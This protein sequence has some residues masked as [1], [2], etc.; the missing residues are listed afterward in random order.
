MGTDTGR[1]SVFDKDLLTCL[2]FFIK[3]G[4]TNYSIYTPQGEYYGSASDPKGCTDM[5]KER[6][7]RLENDKKRE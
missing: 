3:V 6:Q 2:G 4:M 1:V 7:E 5:L